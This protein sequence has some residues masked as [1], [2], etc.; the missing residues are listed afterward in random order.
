MAVSRR[1]HCVLPLTA[2]WLIYLANGAG[3]T[4]HIF[5]CN[6]LYSHMNKNVFPKIEL[7]VPPPSF[8]V[9]LFLKIFFWFMCSED[10]L[11]V[12]IPFAVSMSS[13]GPTVRF[14]SIL[15]EMCFSENC[16]NFSFV[17]IKKN[18]LISFA[19]KNHL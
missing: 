10:G 11:G 18:M 14:L 8:L 6:A 16:Q 2:A 4:L 19:I 5:M 9:K 12:N 13:I 15:R 1:G 7:R 17:K 3:L